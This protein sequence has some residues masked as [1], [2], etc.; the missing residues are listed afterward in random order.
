MGPALH[1][2]TPMHGLLPA[3]TPAQ[4]DCRKR[5]L[6][7]H[8]H[9]LPCCGAFTCAPTE[10]RRGQQA[11]ERG[12]VGWGRGG[13]PAMGV[14][15]HPRQVTTCTC[16]RAG[17]DSY[18]KGAGS[19]QGAAP[20]PR[21]PPGAACWLQPA[22]T[23]VRSHAR[24]HAC[25]HACSRGTGLRAV[26]FPP[27]RHTLKGCVRSRCGHTRRLQASMTSSCIPAPCHLPT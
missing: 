17:Q 23:R 7:M 25:M 24:W 21:P 4:I 8:S 1:A 22:S 9:W 10:S 12:G 5:N 11:E 27:A 2:C 13:C 19:S 6:G 26:R 16:A 18:R 15:I 3:A 14:S 20:P